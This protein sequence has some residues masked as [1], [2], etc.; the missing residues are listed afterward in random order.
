MH[1]FCA[2]EGTAPLHSEVATRNEQYKQ[3]F[4]LCIGM[5]VG[6]LLFALLARFYDSIYL[7][8]IAGGFFGGGG[9]LFIGYYRRKKGL[10]GTWKTR[11]YKHY[12][13]QM[14]LGIL[15]AILYLRMKQYHFAMILLLLESIWFIGGSLHGYYRVYKENKM[16]EEEILHD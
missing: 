8:M 7:A 3:L 13:I 12:A 5:F 1:F 6:C 10:Q 2:K 9:M 16:K 14:V 4:P 15:F 11:S